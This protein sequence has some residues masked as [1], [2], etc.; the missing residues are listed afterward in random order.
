MDR[1]RN[2]KHARTNIT[3]PTRNTRHLGANPTRGPG[4]RASEQPQRGRR[5]LGRRIGRP[6]PSRSPRRHTADHW[7]AAV[8][9]SNATNPTRDTD[10][11]GADPTDPT[12]DT[13]HTG[14]NPTGPTRNARHI[15][16]D[17]T[18]GP[19]ARSSDHPDHGRRTLGRRAG[20]P[21]R[22][23]RRDTVGHE[24]AAVAGS[25]ATNPA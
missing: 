8:A 10:H 23:P 2:T 24:L 15:G 22:S 25:D 20:R 6:S 7:L 16:A 14:T 1:T 13:G 17:P 11:G 12:R 3:D 21:A 5:T 19:S 4:T 9:A 18:R